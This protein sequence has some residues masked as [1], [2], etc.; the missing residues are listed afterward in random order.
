[1]KMVVFQTDGDGLFLYEAVANELPLDPGAFNVPYGAQEVPPPDVP[2][3]YV[4]R[5]DGAKWTSVQDHRNADLWV[6]ST[7]QPY[8]IRTEVE[9][10]GVAVSYMGWGSLPA[11]LTNTAPAEPVS[12]EQ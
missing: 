4:A 3:G 7:G 8:S 9:Q 1:M 12:I 10:D 5:W 11:W 2:V 6:V